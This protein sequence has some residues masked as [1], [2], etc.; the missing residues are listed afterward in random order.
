MPALHCFCI[1]VHARHS[2]MVHG[3]APQLVMSFQWPVESQFCTV[4]IEQRLAMPGEHS[5]PQSCFVVSQTN[6]HV[7]GGPHWPIE[8]QV[9][10]L[11]AAPAAQRVVLGL[12]LPEHTP[13]THALSHGVCVWFIPITSHTTGV[14]FALHDRVPGLHMPAHA[15]ASPEPVHANGHAVMSCQIPDRSHCWIA[16]PEGLQR[17]AA[18]VHRAT[19][20]PA[21]HVGI[22]TGHAV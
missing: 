1:E 6:V 7:A 4:L 5:P 2:P 9:S 11:L 15:E 18:A 8:P 22:S 3:V 20:A 16:V 17:F 10:T 14:L 13:S 21:S 19:Q 12:Q